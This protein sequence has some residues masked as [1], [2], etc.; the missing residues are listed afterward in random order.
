MDSN[1]IDAS[2]NTPYEGIANLPDF[3]VGVPFTRGINGSYTF[4]FDS[5][6]IHA[7]GFKASGWSADQA[8]TTRVCEGPKYDGGDGNSVIT[9]IDHIYFAD[10]S[11]ALST[12]SYIWFFTRTPPSEASAIFNA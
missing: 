4:S 7:Y 2:T 10:A 9:Q 1:S 12:H 3:L 11:F 5:G 6:G 8:G